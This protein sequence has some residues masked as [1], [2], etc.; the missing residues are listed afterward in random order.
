MSEQGGTGGPGRDDG[1]PRVHPEEPAEGPVDGQDEETDVPR[2]HTQE[3][4]EG[5]TE[6]GEPL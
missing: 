3:P 5:A 1:T 6:P 2:R 4:A